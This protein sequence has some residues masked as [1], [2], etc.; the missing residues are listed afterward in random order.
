MRYA[1]PNKIYTLDEY[2]DL[3]YETDAKYEFF[4]DGK[5]VEISGVHYNHSLINGNILSIFYDKL[6]DDFEFWLGSMKLKVPALPPYRYPN[7]SIS[8]KKAVFENVGKHECLV[9]P[10]LIGE[11]FSPET[12]NYDWGEKFEAYKSIESFVEYVLVDQESKFVTVF[13]KYD[14]GIWFQSEYSE[15]DLLTLQSVDCE[16]SVDEIYYRIRFES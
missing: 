11:I 5:L 10:C 3:D 4:D 14:K 7:F 6:S 16:L 2:L 15:G 12:K 9:N 1:I 13:T 8:P